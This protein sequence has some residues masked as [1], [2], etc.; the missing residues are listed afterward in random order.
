MTE[1]TDQTEAAPE[2]PQ[3]GPRLIHSGTYA[4]Y[5]TAAGGRHVVYRRTVTMAT[6]GRIIGTPE[7][8]QVD[9]HLPDFPAEVLPLLA[10]FLE[11]GIPAPIMRILRSGAGPAGLLAQA[12]EL[13]QGGPEPEPEPGGDSA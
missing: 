9:E 7:E 3:A 12:R 10:T 8:D 13:A 2:A 4:L 5:Q 1:A 11:H 6:D